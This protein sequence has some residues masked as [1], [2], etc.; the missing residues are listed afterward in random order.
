MDSLRANFSTFDMV[1]YT[2]IFIYPSRQSP[3]FR[4]AKM[5]SG[6][7]R[8]LTVDC[9]PMFP[10]ILDEALVGRRFLCRNNQVKSFVERSSF[11]HDFLIGKA[12]GDSR[13][14]IDKQ[15]ADFGRKLHRYINTI[16]ASL[17]QYL[18]VLLL[19]R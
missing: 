17:D 14:M 3:D 18:K 7:F 13:P 6:V 15:S 5:R 9:R 10:P 16:I 19:T 1:Y 2:I 11:F 8:R 4:W 12:S